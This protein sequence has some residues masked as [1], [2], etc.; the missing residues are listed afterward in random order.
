MRNVLQKELFTKYPKLLKKDNLEYGISCG[1]GW[2]WLIDEL[3][4][5]IQ[6]YIDLNGLEQVVVF[7]VKQKLGVLRFYT[8]SID[9]TINGAIRFAES[10][11]MSMCEECGSN[12]EVSRTKGYIRTLC[13]RCIK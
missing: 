8:D 10:L 9:Q 3:C 13:K 5:F 6:S 4:D 11:S 7:E 12:E 2:Y 1:D